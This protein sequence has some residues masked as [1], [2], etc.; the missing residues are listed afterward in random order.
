V[1][2]N[3]GNI[4][5]S[6]KITEINDAL[7]IMQHFIDLSSRLLPFLAKLH[8]KENLNSKE[9]SDMNKIISVFNSYNFDVESSEILMNSPVLR[10]IKS[11]YHQLLLSEK[12]KA[13]EKIE[14]FMQEYHRLKNNWK[15]ARLN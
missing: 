2:I 12:E 9:Q 14:P 13:L 15:R 7:V 6:Q 1:K 3:K 10:L 11:S 5:N 8:A 4:L